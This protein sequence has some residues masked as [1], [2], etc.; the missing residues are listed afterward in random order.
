MCTRV[1][2]EREKEVRDASE[3]M[4]VAVMSS[5]APQWQKDFLLMRIWNCK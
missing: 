3:K 4:R 1:P 5:D 2:V